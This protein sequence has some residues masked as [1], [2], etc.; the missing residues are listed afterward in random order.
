MSFKETDIDNFTPMGDLVLVKVAFQTEQKTDSGIIVD[1][2]P[3]VIHSRPNNGIVV[4]QGK[5]V[6][7]KMINKKIYFEKT[8]GQDLSKEYILLQFK[9]ILGY[10]E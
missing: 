10:E 7:I 9:T 2:K 4:K 5:D 6:P 3:D 1:Y 8:R